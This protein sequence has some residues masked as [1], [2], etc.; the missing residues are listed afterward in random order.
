MVELVVSLLKSRVYLS[1]LNLYW[2]LRFRDLQFVSM[3][4]HY[5]LFVRTQSSNSE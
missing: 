4:E 2:V 1:L 3:T 5:P